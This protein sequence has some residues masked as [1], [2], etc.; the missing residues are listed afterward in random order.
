MSSNTAFAEIAALA[1][2]PDAPSR[3]AAEVVRIRLAQQAG[4]KEEAAAA[5][6][7]L[8]RDADQP[9][10]RDTFE[11]AEVLRLNAAIVETLG[12]P[13]VS[14]RLRDL[15][16]DIPTRGQLTPEAL[17]AHQ[18]AEIEKWWPI[19]KAANIKAE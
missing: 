8:L 19:I 2:P 3:V 12:D 11:F 5:A 6:A 16:A 18:K 13:A 17:G 14:A 1:L 4:R 7:Q 9:G 15:G 10:L